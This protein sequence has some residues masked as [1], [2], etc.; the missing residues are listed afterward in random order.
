M[1][2]SMIKSADVREGPNL[3]AEWHI[4]ILFRDYHRSR[5]NVNDI[6][7]NIRFN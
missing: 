4:G 3:V 6:A 7:I 1:K 5:V 2:E